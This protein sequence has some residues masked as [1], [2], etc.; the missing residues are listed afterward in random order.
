MD[1]S[2]FDGLDKALGCIAVALFLAGAAIV[3]LIWLLVRLFA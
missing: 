1:P 2:M 3:G